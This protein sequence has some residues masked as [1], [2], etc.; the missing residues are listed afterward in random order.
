MG[1]ETQIVGDSAFGCAGQ[2]CLASSVAIAVGEAG[3]ILSD[4]IA[5]AA[6]SRVVG[7]GLNPGVQ[8]GPVISG[9]SKV[10]VEGL[11]DVGVKEGA[12]ILVDGRG[13]QIRGYEKG[14]FIKP[15]I[16]ADVNPQ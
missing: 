12:K 9:E 14:N 5:A 13:T 6:K 1:G 15:T 2:R 8:V 16:L 7:Y 11:I 4:S 10:R 3:R